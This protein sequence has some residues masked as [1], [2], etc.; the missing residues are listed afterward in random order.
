[1]SSQK[2]CVY[3][4]PCERWTRILLSIWITLQAPCSDS[5]AVRRFQRE[6]RCILHI[7]TLMNGRCGLEL[8]FWPRRLYGGSSRCIAASQK[9]TVVPTP[10]D[11]GSQTVRCASC[12]FAKSISWPKG[13]DDRT[14]ISLLKRLIVG[15]ESAGRPAVAPEMP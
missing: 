1:M 9:G 8:E 15:R 2:R 3:E 4:G 7:S 5:D 13:L 10:S 6:S 12:R 14:W 11:A